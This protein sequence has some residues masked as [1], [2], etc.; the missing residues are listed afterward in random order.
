[1]LDAYNR[2]VEERAAQGLPPLP[3]SPEQVAELV[4][5]LEN[6]QAGRAGL[7][8]D[9]LTH[10]VPPGVD[11]A[12][13]VKAEFLTALAKGE[14][15]C[16]LIDRKRATELLGT[17]LGGYNLQALIDLLDDEDMAPIAAAGLKKTL[18]VFEAYH[19]VIHKAKT[20][21]WAKD[22]VE[23][24]AEAEWFTSRP[25]LAEELTVTVFKVP[26][27]TNTDDLS[28]ASEAW[29]RPDIPLHAQAMLAAKMPDGLKTIAE[30]K[31]KG[32]PVAFVGDVV[33]TSP[34]CLLHS[35]AQEIVASCR[36]TGLLLNFG[37]P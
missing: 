20:N 5:L 15:H 32:H 24:W 10:R 8:V 28:P 18:L 26:G 14:R 33:G 23:S 2:H 35:T 11:G 37:G 16:S 29:S 36:A 4:A 25:V 19:D 17:M 12:A 22:V 21:N 6:P 27:E 31:Q 3:L 1:M 34:F 30:L 7:L 13:Q 9:L